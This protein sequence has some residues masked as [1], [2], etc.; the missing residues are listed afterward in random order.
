M[1]SIAILNQIS[2][3]NI[4]KHI[5]DIISELFS[6][7]KIDVFNFWFKK[8]II[9]Q[10]NR[11][12][13]SIDCVCNAKRYRGIVFLERMITSPC[14]SFVSKCWFILKKFSI[15]LKVFFHCLVGIYSTLLSLFVQISHFQSQGQKGLVSLLLLRVCFLNHRTLYYSFFWEFKIA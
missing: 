3:I 13:L 2:F 15:S 6:S 10:K 14:F 8:T 11:S 9:P 1:M 7:A 12:T 5:W 4:L